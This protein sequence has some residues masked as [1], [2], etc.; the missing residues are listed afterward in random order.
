MDYWPIGM[1]V[2]TVLLL[3]GVPISMALAGVGLAGVASIIGWMPALSLIGSAFFDNG[4]DYSLSVLPLFLMMG[5]F[6]V[7]SGIAE[8]LY[9]SAYAWLRHRKGGLAMAT[10]VACGAFSSV[11]GSSMATAATM[12]RIGLPSMRRFGYPDRLSTASIAAGGTLGILIPPSVIL[13]FYGIL[14]QQDIGRLF[15]AGLIPGLIGVI[16]YAIAVRISIALGKIDLPTESKLPLSDRIRALKGTA[17]ALVLFVFV[18]GGIYLGVF[19]PTESAGMG[20]G[21]AFLLVLLSGKFTREGMISVLYDTMKTTSMMFFILFGALTF[22]NYVNM[23]GMTGDIQTFLA[24]FGD[25]PLVTILVILCIYLALGCLL[26]SLSMIMLTVPVFYPIMAAQGVDLV[27]FGIFVVMVTEISYITP[28]VGMNAF[29]LRSVVPD[30]PL[31]TIF[32]GLGPFVAMDVLRVALLTAF[33]G[34]VLLL[35]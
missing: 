21:G 2:L 4:R 28:P 7:Q 32:R 10:V 34:L 29:V 35:T 6:V 9:T 12:T 23:S 24:L 11:C 18:M 16:G 33:P 13:V 31:G 30:V 8:E 15:L 25:T 27:W 14:T 17:G 3:L 1:A 22:T 19:T 26:E 20:A 5:N